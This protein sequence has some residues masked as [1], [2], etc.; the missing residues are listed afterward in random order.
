MP[1]GWKIKAILKEKGMTQADLARVTGIDPS[2]ISH[3]VNEDRNVREDTLYKLSRGLHVKPE[4]IMLEG[5]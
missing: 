5:K 4:E 1:Y 2:N 3:I